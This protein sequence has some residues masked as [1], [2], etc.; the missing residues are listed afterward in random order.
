[1]DYHISFNESTKA[2]EN[3]KNFPVLQGNVLLPKNV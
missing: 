1:V 2:D 3:K